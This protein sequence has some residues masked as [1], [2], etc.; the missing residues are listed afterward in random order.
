MPANSRV[1]ATAASL[2][3]LSVVGSILAILRLLLTI[4]VIVVALGIYLRLRG[5]GA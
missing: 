5:R 2:V 4:G 3:V 1:R